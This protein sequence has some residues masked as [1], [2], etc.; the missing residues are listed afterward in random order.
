MER[1]HEILRGWTATI[2]AVLLLGAGLADTSVAEGGRMS[3]TLGAEYTS[4][5]YGGDENIDDVYL[6]L[7]VAWS[8]ENLSARVT[9]PYAYVSAPEGSIIG[10]GND[11]V[12]GSGES[13]SD[14]GLGDVTLAVS[15]LDVYSSRDVAL[16]VTGK[17]KLGTADEEKGLGTGET[18]YTLQL[19]GYVFQDDFLWMATVGYKWRGDSPGLD[20][21]D[22]WFAAGGM[23]VRMPAESRVGTLVSYRPEVVDG[24]EDAMDV[25]LF[26]DRDFAPALGAQLYVLAG[27]TDGSPDWGIGGSVSWSF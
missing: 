25:T 14:S 10:R 21:D 23:A 18:D 5:E 12:I 27:L 15:W 1:N 20:L 19:D 4:G 8:N 2:A 11:V 26:Y 22:T 24:G 3:L 9:V 6:P 7:T 13:R 17:V 16:D